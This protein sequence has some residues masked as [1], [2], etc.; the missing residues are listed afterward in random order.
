MP[1]A[2]FLVLMGFYIVCLCMIHGFG[3]RVT[4]RG[5]AH[6]EAD[7]RAVLWL[8][9]KVVTWRE[10]QAEKHPGGSEH[11]TAGQGHR[12][13]EVLLKREARKLQRVLEHLA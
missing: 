8:V 12:C 11:P 9:V 3:H 2:R 1:M 5:V 7:V 13:L 10:V 6:H 4:L